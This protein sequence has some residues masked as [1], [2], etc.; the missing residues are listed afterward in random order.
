MHGKFNTKNIFL[1]VDLVCQE[2]LSKEEKKHIFLI[3]G[4]FFYK[5]TLLFVPLNKKKHSSN[6]K[7]VSQKFAS[8]RFLN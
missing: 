3:Q 1:Y 8:V 5:Q 7:K 6:H 4:N 2:V